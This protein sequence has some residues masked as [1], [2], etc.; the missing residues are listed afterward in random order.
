MVVSSS[1]ST[2]SPIASGRTAGSACVVSDDMD[3]CNE[4]CDCSH[5]TATSDFAV[6]DDANSAD[7]GTPK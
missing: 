7:E 3:S 1:V 5:G 2:G 6:P 4:H